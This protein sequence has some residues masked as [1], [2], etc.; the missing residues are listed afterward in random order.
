MSTAR[1]VRMWCVVNGGGWPLAGTFDSRRKDA[2]AAY[3]GA[4][5]SG[6]NIYHNDRRRYGVQVARCIVAVEV[7]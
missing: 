2:I 7:V 4:Y 3:N 6:S 1:A 5:G